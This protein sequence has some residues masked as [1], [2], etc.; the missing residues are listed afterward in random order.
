MTL[1]SALLIFDIIAIYAWSVRKSHTLLKH[2]SMMLW[3]QRG[4]Q[5]RFGSWWFMTWKS[6]KVSL[7]PSL[8]PISQPPFWQNSLLK[9][10]KGGITG[11]IKKETRLLNEW[12]AERGTNQGFCLKPYSI[13]L[14][15]RMDLLPSGQ[16]WPYLC[17]PAWVS[18]VNHICLCRHYEHLYSMFWLRMWHPCTKWILVHLLSWYALWRM[19]R[20]QNFK[21]NEILPWKSVEY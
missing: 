18:H 2:Y 19:H 5:G 15:P 20:R 4:V 7:R 1:T 17:P 10:K 14:Y 6:P 21:R 3:I 9:E 8:L 16:E 12:N 11:M 13:N